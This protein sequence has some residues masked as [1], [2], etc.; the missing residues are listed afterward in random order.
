MKN[1]MTV[2]VLTQ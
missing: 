1:D 2:T